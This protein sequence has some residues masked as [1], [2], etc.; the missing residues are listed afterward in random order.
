[1]KVL[2]EKI[3]SHRHTRDIAWNQIVTFKLLGAYLPSTLPTLSVATMPPSLGASNRGVFT[4][5]NFNQVIQL[6]D[7]GLWSCGNPALLTNA[8]HLRVRFLAQTVYPQDPAVALDLI[9]QQREDLHLNLAGES[10]PDN[11]EVHP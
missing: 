5:V 7:N 11:A 1:M 2:L 8:P 10:A 9:V 6:S 4:E 3:H